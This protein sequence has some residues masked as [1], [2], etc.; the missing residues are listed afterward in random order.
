MALP[1]LLAGAVHDTVAWALPAVAVTAEG[2]PG[3]VIGVTLAEAAEAGLVPAALV[4]V[5]VK[6]YAVPLVR[7]LTTAL[8]AGAAT[9][10]VAVAGLEVMVYLVLALPP[11]L[12]CA[13]HVTVAWALPA[14]ALTAVG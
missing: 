8:V 14:F 3:T 11:S 10:I 5:T 2:A 4:A 7:P 9:V 1:P 12:A 13:A 6:V